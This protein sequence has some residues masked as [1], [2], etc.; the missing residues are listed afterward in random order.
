TFQLYNGDTLKLTCEV[1]GKPVPTIK[2]YFESSDQP[3]AREVSYGNHESNGYTDT[4]IIP[5]VSFKNNG[6]YKCLA[7]NT[8]NVDHQSIVI[9]VFVDLLYIEIHRL[10]KNRD[11]IGLECI[12]L[13]N[14]SDVDLS[15]RKDNTNYEPVELNASLEG[16]TNNSLTLLFRE[17]EFVGAGTYICTAKIIG[18]KRQLEKFIFIQ[19]PSKPVTPVKNVTSD[20]KWNVFS[21]LSITDCKVRYGKA[22]AFGV[23]YGSDRYIITSNKV[24]AFRTNRYKSRHPKGGV[25]RL[26]SYI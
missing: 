13:F 1:D 19:P 24:V 16:R 6:T 9:E 18:S 4:L 20:V 15:W 12:L 22:N 25:L 26:L 17:N 11:L 2:W 10:Y 14:T 5:D 7:D 21:G 3:S 8:I 23:R